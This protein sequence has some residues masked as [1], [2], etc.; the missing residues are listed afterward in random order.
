MAAGLL[1]TKTDQFAIKTIGGCN[2]STVTV[3]IVLNKLYFYIYIYIYCIV[4]KKVSNILKHKTNE[5]ATRFSF[6][7]EKICATLRPC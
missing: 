5:C 7:S 6:S 3:T 1:L 2:I 4:I